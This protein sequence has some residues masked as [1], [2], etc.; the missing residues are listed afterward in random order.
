M[1]HIVLGSLALGLAGFDPLGIV[2]LIAAMALGAK[3]RGILALMLSVV[4]STFVFG[5]VPALTLGPSVW[6]LSRAMGRVSHTVWGPLTIAVG[7]AVVAWGILRLWRRPAIVLDDEPTLAPRST[8]TGALA[9]TGLLVG[10]S[11]FIDPAFYGII[12]LAAHQTNPVTCAWMILLWIMGSH[13]ALVVV[14]L[15]ALLGLHEP[16]SRWIQHVRTRWA[17][18]LVLAGSI[19]LVGIGVCCIVEGIFEWH[20]HWLLLDDLRQHRPR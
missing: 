2:A 7:L 14:G 10:L 9:L 13:C 4:V 18:P 17:S 5:L 1:L 6:Q 11:A 8:S 19:A 20:H 12:V 15:A 3:R 16:V